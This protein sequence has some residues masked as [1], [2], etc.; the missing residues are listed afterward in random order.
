MMDLMRAAADVAARFGH[1]LPGAASRRTVPS[2]V[3]LP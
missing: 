3:A 2:D 1:L